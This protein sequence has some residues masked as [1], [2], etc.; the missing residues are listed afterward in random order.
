MNKHEFVG[1]PLVGARLWGRMQYAPTNVQKNNQRNMMP[2]PLGAQ[3]S[4]I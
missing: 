4:K 2:C 3:A 1:A